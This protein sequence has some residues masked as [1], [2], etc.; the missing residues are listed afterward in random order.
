MQGLGR[1]SRGIRHRTAVRALAVA[2]LACAAALRAPA[3]EARAASTIETAY[4]ATGGWAVS[5]GTAS[6]FGGTYKLYYPTN[7]GAGGFRHPILTWGNGTNATPSKY[8]GILSH[9][10]SWGFVVIASNS[11]QTGLGTEI[12]NGAY[13]LVNEDGNPSSI[14]YQKL[15]IA[16]V[17][18]LGHSQGAGGTLN[19]TLASDGLITSALTVALPD[20]FW[21]STPVPDMSTFPTDTPIFFVRGTSDFLATE[22]AAT[23]WY[24]AVP[25]PAAKAAQKSAG[26]NEVQKSTTRL[27]G[28]VTAWMMYTLRGDAYARGAFVGSPPEINTNT[29]WQNV[30]EKNLP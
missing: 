19:A 23:N 9:L 30:A 26:H 24:N 14:F 13:H 2:A 11:G 22:S 8:D 12:L 16:N 29:A 15:D 28:Y 4:R 5:T 18:A 7:L 1:P 27:K 6:A 20:P 17:G 3:P 25:G 10:A 21:W